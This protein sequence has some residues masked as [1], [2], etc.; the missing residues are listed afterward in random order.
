QNP[1][2]VI[3]GNSIYDK[4]SNYRTEYYADAAD[5]VLDATGNWWGS[6]DPKVIAAKIYDYSDRGSS[7][8]VDFGGYLDG[9]DGNPASTRTH[10]TGPVTGTLSAGEYEVL[11]ALIVPSGQTLTIPAGATLSFIAGAQLQV[12]GELIIQGDVDNQVLLTSAAS[13]PSKSDWIGIVVANWATVSL[14]HVIV[15]YA[16][17]AIELYYVTGATVTVSNSELRGS[18]YGLYMIRS[19]GELTITGSTLTANGYGVY[20]RG[21]IS[22]DQQ[23]PKPVITGNS[24]YD[25]MYY[26]YYTR[27]YANAASIVLNATGNWWGSADPNVI[28]VEIANYCAGC[29]RPYVDFRGYLDG[30]AGN[31]ASTVTPLL[32]SVTGTLSTGWHEVLG[33]LIVPSGQTLTIP[34]GATL[35]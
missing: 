32:G 19:D 11:G 16:Y 25:N 10:L 27:D 18:E 34:A 1:L 2:P 13:N 20:L 28:A 8:V 14:D 30:I 9:D 21:N 33:A 17:K 7:P 6:T 15:E 5:T 31:P 26:N 4:T 22:N 3:T 24:I 12:F 29:G 23:S 35:S